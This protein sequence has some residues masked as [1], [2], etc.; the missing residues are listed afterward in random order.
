MS[1]VGNSS[2]AGRASSG[3]PPVNR[4]N[5]T[6]RRDLTESSTNQSI[7]NVPRPV[8]AQA[9]RQTTNVPRP[10]QAQSSRR[11]TSVSISSPRPVNT[12][13]VARASG[14]IG[15]TDSQRR[16]SQPNRRE[17]EGECGICLCNLHS[18]QDEDWDEEEE[19]ENSGGEDHADD[20]QDDDDDDDDD[21][22]TDDEEHPEELVWCKARCGVNF[23]KKCI[24]QWLETDHAST[25]P[26]CRS[27]W[28]H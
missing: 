14:R 20:D 26:T 28:K 18:S 21:D 3:N 10:V 24:D 13:T 23:H 6:L 9:S 8:Q 22:D 2:T 15:N 11:A 19:S 25:C 4:A 16:T 1:A 5:E 17:I 7:I 27:N 12:P